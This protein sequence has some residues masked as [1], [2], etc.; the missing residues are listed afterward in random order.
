MKKILN[1]VLV[2]FMIVF[3][4]GCDNNSEKTMTCTRKVT[5]T[6]DVK[7]DL[8]YKATYKNDVV[9]RIETVEK[10]ISS[11]DSVLESYKNQLDSVYSPYAKVEYYDT[12]V[13]IDGD[14]LISNTKI[15]YSKIDIDELIEI[16]SANSSLI[17]KDGKVKID[18][19]RNIY[20]KVGATCK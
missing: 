20:E 10:I 4:A 14:T 5:V 9:S 1:I 19:V 11:D 17:D 12:S 18:T 8:L 7:M 6:D 16:D 2:C 13:E 15:D 3:L